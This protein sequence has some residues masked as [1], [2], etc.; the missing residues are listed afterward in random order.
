MI[1]VSKNMVVYF[2]YI[3][4]NNKGEVIENTMH[5]LPKSYLHGSPGI[6]PA[7]QLQFE[8]LRVGDIKLIHLSTDSGMT[9]DYTFDVV[10]DDLRPALEEELLLGY[11]L[12]DADTNCD[13]DCICYASNGPLK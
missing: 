6:Q 7:L 13:K 12:P 4:R 2:R 10:I 3:M 11:S 5:G 9:D 8:G 1:C